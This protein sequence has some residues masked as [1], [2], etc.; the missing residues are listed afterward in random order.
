MRIK[1]LRF[2]VLLLA[3]FTLAACS[4]DK[5]KEQN[6]P[7]RTYV[8]NGAEDFLDPTVSLEDNNRFTFFYSA[9]SSYIAMGSYEIEDDKLILKTDDGM[10]EYVF[11]IEN[12]TL[13]FNAGES[14]KL[15]AYAKVPDGAVFE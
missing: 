6:L 5:S 14:S 10:N 11:K 4:S 12:E 1:F 3:A 15:P 2:M 13:I 9:L 8:M 7:V